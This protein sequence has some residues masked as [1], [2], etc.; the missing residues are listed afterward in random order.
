MTIESPRLQQLATALRLGDRAA[1]TAFWAEMTAVGTPLIE[2][3]GDGDALVTFLWR[4]L[5]NTQSVV[6]IQDWGADGIY[7]HF[8]TP[9][10][11]SD[12]W[13]K[14]RVMRSDTRTTYQLAPT[15]PTDPTSLLPYQLDPLNPHVHIVSLAE[16]E[17][18]IRFSFLELPDAPA[19]PWK[20]STAPKGTVQRYQ[21]PGSRR[22]WVYTAVSIAMGSLYDL[23]GRLGGY[24][25][26]IALDGRFYKDLLN[27]P[28]MLDHLVAT[29]Q[30]PPLIALFIDQPNRQE[31]LCAPVFADYFA[32]RVMPWL[33]ENF[34]VTIDP[35]QILLTG[36]SYGGLAAVYLG[37][38]HPQLFGKILSQTGWFRW[39][40][41]G[42]PDFHWLAQQVAQSPRLPLRFYLDVGTLEVAQ[43]RDGGPTQLAANRHLRDVLVSK[44]YPVTYVEYS[45]GH[46][47]SSLENPLF[48]ALAQMLKAQ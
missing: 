47:Y 21:L 34:P 23:P 6:V 28:A 33:R 25:L 11:D 45:G 1:L 39:H 31:L 30:I 38:R 4:D 32:Q 41:A 17:N 40:P 36:S 46:D 9:L 10:S 29:R 3:K 7:E 27:L 5:G 20:A 2:P 44:G 48:A 24:P 19:Q 14:T 16:D 26:L 8:M 15:P 35:A 22:A 13:F 37:L 43:M 18:H 12:I 42:A